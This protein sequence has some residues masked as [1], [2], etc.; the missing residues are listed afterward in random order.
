MDADQISEN[1]RISD[2]L[3][4]GIYS[5]TEPIK[6][7]KPL[8]STAWEIWHWIFDENGE[9]INGK[10][11]CI[12]CFTV[13]N[14]HS[15]LGT[16]NLLKHKDDCMNSNKKKSLRALSNN[17]IQLIKS[18]VN[19]KVVQFV[20]QD[21]RA[22]RTTSCPGFEAL[23]DKLIA[24]G[25][26]YGPIKS[27]DILPH[28]TS[29]PKLV[30]EEA[31][32]KRHLLQSKLLVVQS[33][34]VAVTVD[35][36]TEDY[37]KCHYIGMNIHYI[38]EGILN[39]TTLCVKELDELSANA[40]NIH[41][42]IVN[43]LD[44]FE[45]DM[46]NVIFVSDRGSEIIAALKDCAERL[47]CSAHILKN[48]VDEMLKKLSDENA[49][50][51]LLKSCRELVT[52]IKQSNIQYHLPSALKSE[53]ATRWNATLYMLQSIQKAQN[54][55]HLN[56]Y[57][58]SKKRNDL[59]TNIDN[60]LLEELIELLEPF[61]EATLQFESTSSPTS[62]Y[63]A[64]HRL[65]LEEHLTV[66]R[67]DSC[68]IAEMKTLGLTYMK[69]NW[70]VDDVRK[71]SV[72]FHPKLKKMSMFTDGQDIIDQIRK[73]AA[74]ISDLNEEEHEP[75]P[76]RR[77]VSVEDRIIDDFCNSNF[78]DEPIDE[79]QQYLNSFVIVP[80]TGKIDLCQY[81]YENRELFPTLYKLSLKY[82]CVPAASA[83]AESKFSL[84]GFV[85]N[86][87]RHPINPGAV[88]DLLLLKSL[89]D[90]PDLL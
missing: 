54:T 70:I 49:V 29:I 57:L 60:D 21:L 77:K 63:I 14:Y 12:R 83:S 58:E 37:T 22:F 89:F 64:L 68:H 36:W 71:K 56:D 19:K 55:T 88:D 9:K 1:A 44:V 7:G 76:K 20:A 4:S 35:L 24:I 27:S 62:H 5:C 33:H 3:R 15:N 79:I 80:E 67:Y 11:A 41:I 81:W 66:T 50:K 6:N 23:A 48:I 52:F 39:E 34:G 42:E 65:K 32:N 2:N 46:Q 87:K 82:L 26:H 72:F 17:A 90:K 73:E 30:A 8:R 45:I 78:S 40:E 51:R 74:M 10:I 59:L 85:V 13:V 18:S 43:M 16:T 69:N 84:A 38:A 47:N 53:V 86:E 61:L 25:H 75:P 28:R 31:E